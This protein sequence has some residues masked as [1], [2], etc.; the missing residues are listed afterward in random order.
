MRV[1]L[2]V[3]C[4]FPDHFYGTESYTRTV[5]RELKAL[6]HEPVVVTA[7]FPSEPAQG[8]LVERDSFDGI[9]VIR[10]DRNVHPNAALRDTFHL[11]AL[12]FIHERIL[13]DIR[14]DIVHVCHLINHTTALLEVTGRLGLPTVATFTDFFGFCFNNKLDAADGSLC[15]GPDADR[16]NCVACAFF[17]GGKDKGPVQGLL[18]AVVPPVVAR[19]PRLAPADW[20]GT[21]AA[22]KERPGHLAAAYSAYAGA[23]TPTRF[24]LESYRRSDIRVPLDLCRFG[25]D[26]DRAPKPERTGGPLRLGFIGQ[27]APHKGL[28]LLLEAMKSA[29]ADALSLDIYGDER[30]DPAYAGEVRAAAAG[31]QVAFRGTFPVERMAAVLAEIDVLVIPSVWVEN[32]PLILL[33]ALATHTPVLVS[34]VEGMSEFVENGVNGFTFTKGSVKALY[35]RLEAFTRDPGLARTLSAGTR[36]DRTSRHMVEDVV[37]FYDRARQSGASA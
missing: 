22:L 4:Y 27:L 21:I 29:P 23:L 28:H 7:T 20:R 9:P 37:A 2:Y 18:R 19:A 13:R 17:A 5:A 31:L 36:Y 10:I 6:G 34:D 14:P 25:I 1:A 12:R 30:M 16:A 3:H 35:G 24:M 33:Q 15:A 8:A 11:P 32:S 26:I